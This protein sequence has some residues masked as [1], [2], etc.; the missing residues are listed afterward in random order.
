MKLRSLLSLSIIV[1]V[2]LVSCASLPGE[3]SSTQ[4]E[5]LSICS[6]NIRFLGLYKEIDRDDVGLARLLRSFDIV[7][8][9]ELVAPPIDVT[10]PDGDT[11]PADPEAKEFFDAMEAEGFSF[12]LSEEDT[13]TNDN[14]HQ[15]GSGTEWWV[16]F[17][18][19]ETVEMAPDLPNGFLADDRSNHDDYERVPYAFSFRTLDGLL[20]FVLISVH[21]QPDDSSADMA[22]RKHEIESVVGWI[23]GGNTSEEDFIILGDMNT[24]DCGELAS[25]TPDGYASLNATCETT[26]TKPDKPRPYDHVLYKTDGSSDVDTAYGF[27]VISLVQEMESAWS[28]GS[29]YPGNPYA[30]DSFYQN[31]SDHNPVHFQLIPSSVDDD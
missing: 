19:P 13:G 11:D 12:W 21:L 3:E 5:P 20:D 28:S 30:H 31:Y 6:F 10:Y 4:S 22:R 15:A 8:V 2:F 23:G 18:R 26:N 27:H 25:F 9:Q 7:V 24:K 1:L 14:I 17:Y 29:P 16:A